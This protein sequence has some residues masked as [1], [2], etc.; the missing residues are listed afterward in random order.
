MP[1][2]KTAGCYG[3][4][5]HSVIELFI[6]FS[7]RKIQ[8]IFQLKVNKGFFYFKTSLCCFL[9][10]FFSTMLIMKLSLDI[11]VDKVELLFQ[12]IELGHKTCQC[13]L[14]PSSIPEYIK[15]IKENKVSILL[16]PGPRSQSYFQLYHPI[17]KGNRKKKWR[18]FNLTKENR[19][20]QMIS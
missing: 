18:S 12:D 7:R 11:K 17:H 13:V 1:G 16:T 20:N 19:I 10:W 9:G 8:R 2:S 5:S 6:L 4:S 15:Y 3:S 14:K